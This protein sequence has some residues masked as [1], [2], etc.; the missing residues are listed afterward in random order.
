MNNIPTSHQDLLA[1]ETKAIAF[2]ATTMSDGSPQVTPVWFNTDG[3]HIL[4]NTAK[5]RIKDR[6]MRAHAKIAM[7]ILD[8]DSLYRYI[9]IR[10]RVIN[11]TEDGAREHI[12][13]LAG[14]YTDSAYF[15]LNSHNEVR[16]I[17]KI[18]PE[19]IDAH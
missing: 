14:K 2:L 3:E 7:A 16:V 11:Y 6:N 17:F 1:D 4:I 10:G 8:P 18:L 5:D 9:Q 19:N 12:N 15:E 13:I